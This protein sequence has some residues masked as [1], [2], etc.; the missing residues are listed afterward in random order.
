M[1]N[2]L[3]LSLTSWW[4]LSFFCVVIVGKVEADEKRMI[5]SYC[6]S[7]F[8]KCLEKV[9]AELATLQSPQ[10]KDQ[11]ILRKALLLIIFGQY[12]QADM[13]LSQLVNSAHLTN[14]ELTEAMVH[15]AKNRFLMGDELEALALAQKAEQRIRQMSQEQL[16]WALLVEYGSLL[17]YSKK[18][19]ES[20]QVLSG[21]L[22]RPM[23]KVPAT[24]LADLYATL[25][26]L[27]Y[28]LERNQL[29]VEYMRQSYQYTLKQGNEQQNGVSAHNLARAYLE[30]MDYR[31]ARLL[32]DRAIASAEKAG[33]TSSVIYN[34]YHLIKMNIEMGHFRIALQLHND[35]VAS[36][37][38]A[39]TIVTEQKLAELLVLINNGLYRD[40]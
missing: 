31:R 40:Y 11:T 10:Q 39:N 27:A 20:W 28:I 36:D 17:M 34:R 32:F 9:N 26:Q 15:H 14:I 3:K 22:K 38:S 37:H 1:V 2:Y 4:L 8:D 18:Y 33:D 21:L 29:M 12:E 7:E 6:D 24:I 19:R 5:E 13:L 23:D 30:N 35:L 25:G 16:G